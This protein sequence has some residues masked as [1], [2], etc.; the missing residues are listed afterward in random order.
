MK[1]I[2]DTLQV[3]GKW[4]QKRVM[5]FTSFWVATIYAFIPAF[6][7]D[8]DVKEFV[9]LGFIGGGAYAIFRAQKPNENNPYDN[10]YINNQEINNNP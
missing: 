5:A 10:T 4:S 7:V 2:T 8:F 9:F 3:N 1:L 6:V